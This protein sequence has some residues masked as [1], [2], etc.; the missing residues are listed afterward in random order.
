M[1]AGDK[2]MVSAD[3]ARLDGLAWFAGRGH[4]RAHRRPAPGAV[5]RESGTGRSGDA[6]ADGAAGGWVPEADAAP[7][8]RPPT[9]S[10]P[11]RAVIR[12]AA[13]GARH[14]VLPG[15]FMRR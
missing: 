4:A 15:H 12:A 2:A 7:A 1:A 5:P 8:A 9:A 13:R 3:T 6:F 14:A 11:T 10:T